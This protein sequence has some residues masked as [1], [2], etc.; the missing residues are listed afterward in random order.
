MIRIITIRRLR[1]ILGANVRHEQRH[2]IDVRTMDGLRRECD[3]LVERNGQL[4]AD[5]GV[6]Q[7]LLAEHPEYRSIRASE[8]SAMDRAAALDKLLAELQVANEGAYRDALAARLEA[9][10]YVPKPREAS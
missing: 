4:V 3:A 2:V 8:R 10:P 9:T 6:L 5:A 7:Q 1:R